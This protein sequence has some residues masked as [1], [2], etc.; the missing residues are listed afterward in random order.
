MLLVATALVLYL[1][2]VQLAAISTFFV[3]RRYTVYC[4][5]DG[6][7][8]VDHRL[9]KQAA[10]VRS[11]LSALAFVGA[12]PLMGG[13]GATGSKGLLV[14][15]L[16]FLLLGLVVSCLIGA[17]GRSSAAV[18]NLSQRLSYRRRCQSSSK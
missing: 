5:M 9:V 11:S 16:I 12:I 4:A 14:G 3:Q 15:Y 2:P 8:V 13:A 1:F 6:G 17:T 18:S 10:A 7:D